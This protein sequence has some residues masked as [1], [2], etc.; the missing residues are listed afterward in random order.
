MEESFKVKIYGI[1]KV[2]YED[3]IERITLNGKSGEFTILKDFHN[4]IGIIRKGEGLIVKN[5]KEET[6]ALGDGIL[7]FKDNRLN[8]FVE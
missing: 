7:E 8:I 3:E 6:I 4:F 5:G 2:I 1:D